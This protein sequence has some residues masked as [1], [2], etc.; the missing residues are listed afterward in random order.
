MTTYTIR[1]DDSDREHLAERF[2]TATLMDEN[3]DHLTTSAGIGD[4]PAEALDDL[5]EEVRNDW[6]DAEFKAPE[7]IARMTLGNARTPDFP[8]TIRAAMEDAR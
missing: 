5:L 6:L 2:W 3:G 4:S 1:I 7:P 8:A